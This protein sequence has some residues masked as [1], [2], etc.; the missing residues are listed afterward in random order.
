MLTYYPASRRFADWCS[1]TGCDQPM[2][3]FVLFLSL[4]YLSHAHGHPGVG[5]VIGISLAKTDHTITRFD[6]LE[7]R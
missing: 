2:C 4:S 5:Q 6:A 3:D 7:A 1:K